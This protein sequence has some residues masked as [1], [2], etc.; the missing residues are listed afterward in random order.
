MHIYFIKNEI[1]KRLK[2]QTIP[3]EL[4]ATVKIYCYGTNQY[5]YDWLTENSP[6]PYEKVAELME[7]SIPETLRPFLCS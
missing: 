6:L 1:R 2:T 7:A 5:L 4:D 3:E